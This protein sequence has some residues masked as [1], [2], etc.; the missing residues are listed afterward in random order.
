MVPF[1][2]MDA[3][4]RGDPLASPELIDAWGELW[5]R[6]PGASVFQRPEFLRAWLPEFG[7]DRSPRTV[8]IG[9]RD[10]RGFASLSVDPDGIL[11]FLG[12][13]EV[14]DYFGPLSE[15][16]ERDQVAERIVDGVLAADGWRAA[17][18]RRLDAAGGWAG[19]LERAAK[20][21][22]LTVAIEQD[23]VCPRVAI[24]GSF[25]GYLASLDSKL[26]HEIKRKAR[27]LEREAGPFTVRL[28]G[29]GTLHDDMETFFELHRTS[30]GPK[31]HFL[32][33]GMAGFFILLARAFDERGWLRLTML[34]CGGE[35]VAAVLSFALRGTWSVYNSGFDH[36]KRDLAPGMVLMG[37]TI[38]M[39]A[40]EGAH[41][42]DLLRGDEPYKYR[43]GAV[44][45]PLVAVRITR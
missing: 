7:G 12:D 30:S 31:G 2:V 37:E 38:R 10:L 13:P 23:D 36:R 42:V 16:D 4:V 18:L 20:A 9:D 34:D 8:T 27:K 17:E 28:G 5:E 3:S 29:G 32:H 39:A 41:T 1:A 40:D 24:P 44:D 33:W 22:G 19:A 21:A 11:R 25:D 26:R 45:A 14:T 15:P 35:T 43:F 6:D